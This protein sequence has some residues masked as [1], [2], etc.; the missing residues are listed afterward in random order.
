MTIVRVRSE[1]PPTGY[2]LALS[3]ALFDRLD[4]ATSKTWMV[5][6]TVS[7][8]DVGS[9]GIATTMLPNFSVLS[10]CVC[11]RDDAR[12]RSRIHQADRT[13]QVD[14]C[15]TAQRIGLNTRINQAKLRLMFD[16]QLCRFLMKKA[17]IGSQLRKN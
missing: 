5:Q 17:R 3:W 14:N 1:H 9:A 7:G 10:D 15:G 12:S 11:W 13:S 2:L 16:R 8:V 6:A 4:Q